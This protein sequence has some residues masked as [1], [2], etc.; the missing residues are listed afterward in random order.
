MHTHIPIRYLVCA[1]INKQ[2][3][4]CPFQINL[5]EL[6]YSFI[7]FVIKYKYVIF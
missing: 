6:F 3:K 4:I 2:Y 7:V 1:N 5:R